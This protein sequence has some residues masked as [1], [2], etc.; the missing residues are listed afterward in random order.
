MKQST[1]SL[2]WNF[3]I[4]FLLLC[5]RSK[6]LRTFAPDSHTRVSFT[7][8][9]THENTRNTWIFFLRFWQF[10]SPLSWWKF[11]EQYGL[12]IEL[13]LQKRK[14]N[15]NKRMGIFE[16]LSDVGGGSLPHRNHHSIHRKDFLSKKEKSQE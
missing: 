11:S 5:L 14:E 8:L 15:N 12:Y 16:I 7:K 2:N 1:I 9:F 6:K 4:Q 3:I 10:C 13:A